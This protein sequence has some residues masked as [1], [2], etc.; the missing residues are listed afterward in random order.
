MALLRRLQPSGEGDFLLGTARLSASALAR[1]EALGI[2]PTLHLLSD[3]A[4]R[5]LPLG[6]GLEGA[7]EGL[8]ALAPRARV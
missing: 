2:P 7:V 6:L 4:E 3:F 8:G 5:Q 1:A